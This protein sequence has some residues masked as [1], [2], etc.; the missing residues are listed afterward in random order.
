MDEKGMAYTRYD[1]RFPWNEDF[2]E[3][4]K[5][6]DCMHQINWPKILDSVR[7]RIHPAHGVM[8]RG[9]GFHYYWSA[10]QTEWATDTVFD[11]AEALAAIYPPLVLNQNI[12]ALPTVEMDSFVL[13]GQRVFQFESDFLKC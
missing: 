3:A 6:F 5:M 9:L 2:L 12:N 8:F 7:R 11:S 10:F 1:N 13:N 4:Q